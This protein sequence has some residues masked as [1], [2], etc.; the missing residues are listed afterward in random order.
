MTDGQRWIRIE[1]ELHLV[2]LRTRR[3][4]R[5][6]PQ[7]LEAAGEGGGGTDGGAAADAVGAH[8][9]SARH[10]ALVVSDVG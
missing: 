3:P 5:R 9:V 8:A 10:G 4:V 2:D 6:A 7:V 1:E